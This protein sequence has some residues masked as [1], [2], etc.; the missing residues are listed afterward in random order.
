MSGQLKTKQ[1]RELRQRLKERKPEFLR[2][3][4]DK[5]FKLGRQEKWR[6]PYGRDNKTR[7]KIRGFPPKVSVGYRL[8]KDIRYLHPTGLKKVIVNNV[9]ELIKLKDQ[10]D[11]VIVIIGGTVGFKK[12]LDII[13]KA[14]ELGIKVSNEGVM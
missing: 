10:K 12:R 14:K 1:Y 8:P 9:D 2:Y 3:D 11:N 6:R 4:A 13:N 5:F 7:L